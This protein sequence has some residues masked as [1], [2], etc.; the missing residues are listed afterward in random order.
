MKLGRIE[1]PMGGKNII[2]E[3]GKL[4]KQANAAVTV[5]C[6]GTTVLVTACMSKKPG[7]M[8]FFPL[9]VEYQE[10]TYAAGRI[11]GGFFKRE[12]R[13]TQKE[14]LTSRVI[15]RPIRPLFPNGFLNEVQVVATVLSSDGENDPDIF[16]LIGASAALTISDIPFEGPIGAVRLGR[17]DDQYVLNPTYAQREISSIDLIVVGLKDGVVMIEGES[18]EVEEPK[19]I[20]ALQYAF[21]KLQPIREVQ[22]DLQ[23]QAGKPKARVALVTP[24]PELKNKVAELAKGRLSEIYKIGEKEQREDALNDLLDEIT[25]DLSVFEAYTTADHEISASDIK[26]MFEQVEYEEVRRLIFDE[27]KRA[28]GRGP[29]DIRDISV[30][31]NVLPRTHGSSLFTRG[32]TQSLATVTLGTRRDEQ[33]VEA[34]EGVSYY[35]FMLHYNFPS[36]SVGETKP[37]RG[38]GR[39]EIGHG[40]LAAKAL[41]AVLPEKEKFPYTIRVVSEIL[42]SNGSSSMASVCAGCLSLMD[43]GVP[44]KDAVAGISIG[45]ITDHNKHCLLTDIMGLEDHFGD[46]DFKVAGTRKGITAI[47]LDLKIKGV[48]VNILFQ[49]L[50]QAREAR[51][52]IL[53]VMQS[54]IAKPKEDISEFAPRIIILQIPQDKIGEVIG[55]GGKTIKRIIEET[56]VESIDIDDDGKVHVAS[57]SKEAAQ[58]AVD[59]VHGLVEVP[60]V[61]K[62]YDAVVARITNFGVFCEFLP[63]KQGLVH[64]SELSN[65]FVKDVNTVVKVG[66]TF[67][68]KLIEI[69][70]MKRINLSK[71]QAETE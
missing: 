30:E 17:V 28:D 23:K 31:V 29:K 13:P 65:K 55:P 52:K 7:T 69:D 21:D 60:E 26:A 27:N 59:F 53:D 33:L 58:K 37:M 64:V 5:S 54:V 12:G 10:K 66:D 14:I 71:K 34:L 20:E 51:L 56:G 19:M 3:T 22:Y 32:Q 16:A 63:G 6:G 15:D 45:L 40:A 68:V 57:L 24:H 39:R 42:E 49:G 25:S 8:D 61:G 35:N 18:Q 67:K 44:I 62:I 9:M 4:A 2:I 43:A 47:Q 38:P 41:T 70:Q 48:A 11:P 36:F 50:E 46:M 1:I